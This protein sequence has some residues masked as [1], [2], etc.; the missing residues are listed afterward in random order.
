MK[1]DARPRPKANKQ[2]GQRW[3]RWTLP[4]LC[5]LIAGTATWA[6]CE[7]VIWNVLPPELIGKWVVIEPGDQDGATFDF[8]RNGSLE[9]RLN[10]QGNEFILNARVAL[11]GKVLLT[12]TQNPSTGRDETRKSI[13]RELTENSLIVEFAFARDKAIW[14]MVRAR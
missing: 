3:P 10:N 9:A 12:T 6:F 11:D 5:L 13:I 2:P 4:L 7:L 14:K 8:Y 1:A